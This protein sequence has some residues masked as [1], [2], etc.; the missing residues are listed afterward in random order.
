MTDSVAQRLGALSAHLEG[1]E[2]AAEGFGSDPSAGA[3]VR[4]IAR[5]LTTAAHSRG[6]GEIA[7]G[8]A[9]IRKASDAQLARSVAN[10]LD[11]IED[12][13]DDFD[14]DEVH[15]LIVEDNKTVAAATRA[16]LTAPGRHLHVAE[17]A[18]DAETILADL[19]IDLVVLDLILPDRDGRDLLVQMREQPRTATVPVI[20]LSSKGGSVARAECLAVGA[21]DFIEKPAD[22]KAL[23]AA[24][25]KQLRHVKER[26]D[27]MR[28][29]LTGLPNRAGITAE[30]ERLR[31]DAGTSVAPLAVA[32]LALDSL[33]PTIAEMGGGAGDRLLLEVSAAVHGSFGPADSLGR[34]EAA[35]LVALL[36]GRTAEDARRVLEHTVGTLSA[37]D[38]LTEYSD[39]GVELALSG[40][41]ALVEGDQDLREA[42]S[43]AK[44]SLYQA[45]ST[46][47][48]SSPKLTILTDDAPLTLGLQRILLVEDD[49][50]TATLLHHRLIRDGHEVMDFLNGEEAFEWATAEDFDLA[51]LDVKVPGMD[52]F[53][54]LERLRKVPRYAD[55]PIIMLTGMG[56]E[57]DVI[58]GLEL[59]ADDYMLKPFSP[60]ELL[61]RVRRLLHAR[62][63][64]EPGGS[65][66]PHV[67][68]REAR[69]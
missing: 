5:S 43:A 38:K 67:G 60:S 63:G 58:R 18:W 55:V 52:G 32:I 17:C 65:G 46:P 16:Y 21:N 10:F 66:G 30:Y 19:E 48:P 11:R 12:L 56:S 39:A 14:V 40:G 69:A 22:P 28:D 25:A 4:R 50:V 27:A 36:P 62:A 45:K 35:E 47:K 49:R 1:L 20:V 64:G 15:I 54:L 61:A 26:F 37:G 7:A 9:A 24:V 59:G 44:R 53:E 42:V 2:A 6:L 31:Q 57:A 29:G 34:W 41:V 8:A 33:G 51:I 68:R 13:R 23:R 3:S